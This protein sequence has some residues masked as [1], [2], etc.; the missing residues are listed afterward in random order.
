VRVLSVIAALWF[1]TSC[2]GHRGE[3]AT[4]L[5]GKLPSRTPDSLV[6]EQR[7]SGNILGFDLNRPSGLALNSQGDLY[8]ADAGNNRVIKLDQ[9]FQPMR[10]LGGFGEGYGRFQDPGDLVMD[11]D[12]S[13]YVLDRG[14]R[15]V[16]HL[17]ANLGFV[18]V[19]TP[20][21]APNEMISNLGRL[22][23]LAVLSFGE[24]VVADYDNSRLIRLDNM[25]RFSRYIGDFGY[26]SGALLN[27]EGIALDRD[28][29]IYVA[30]G[31]NG[32]VAV[33]DTY[34][35]FIGGIGR[36]ILERPLAVTVGY[37]D[38]IWVG[39]HASQGIYIFALDGT[40]LKQFSQ[41]DD[42]GQSFA[43]IEALS[44]SPDG[45][46]YV[47]DSGHNRVLVYH[48]VYGESR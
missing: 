46:L 5:S 13:L 15:R 27:P 22:S 8:I 20:E 18:D 11:R 32:R 40:L 34:G 43:D 21:D 42:D 30:D 45:I 31:G 48:I 14:N 7:I 10:D 4:V 44:L 37:D 29:R 47:A 28:G 26:G 23:G 19:I 12:L 35:N 6:L 41:A 9:R 25:R 33:Y 3:Q 16:V 38:L 39:D 36:G 1:L 24:I 17:D 2:A